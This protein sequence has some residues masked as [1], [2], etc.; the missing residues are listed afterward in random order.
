MNNR[1]KQ[2]RAEEQLEK[3]HAMDNNLSIGMK[4][5]A[6]AVGG[7]VVGALT[8]GIGLVPYIAVVGAAAVA[9]GGA[10]FVFSSSFLT[11][12]PVAYQYR[13]PSDSR[14]I[15]GSENS[16]EAAAWKAAIEEQIL[17]L[18][19]TRKPM[20]PATADPD[21]IS[22]ILGSSSVGSGWTKVGQMEGMRIM[23]QTDFNNERNFTEDMLMAI[24]GSP[25]IPPPTGRLCRKAQILVP[26]SPINAFLA[27][28]ELTWPTP[29]CTHRVV[30]QVDDHV[31]ILG[32]CTPLSQDRSSVCPWLESKRLLVG[33]LTR[34]WFLDD[35]GSYMITLSPTTN[36]EF[37][38][39]EDRLPHKGMKELPLS[40]DAVFTVS[41][42]KNQDLFDDD[43][44]QALVT[45][46]VQIN[47]K[48]GTWRNVC[49]GTR[50]EFLNSFVVQ[51][52]DLR[53]R[54]FLSK[55]ELEGEKFLAGR[56][57]PCGTTRPSG[58]MSPNSTMASG[59]KQPQP[60]RSTSG[61]MHTG[62]VTTTQP[63]DYSK[64]K[65]DLA[66]GTA[67]GDRL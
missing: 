35:D 14:L 42:H 32:V 55:F 64:A 62:G 53:D 67:G 56:G 50:N 39:P 33:A 2:R 40:L 65:K 20:L 3:H 41:P 8:A 44:R 37:P 12:L 6:V 52:L 21:V 24:S 29:Q 49:E 19:A 28:M 7:V 47:T 16:Q 54:I 25:L 61:E 51:L 26:C 27:L 1:D 48:D 5:A 58:S 59:R 57:A 18:E 22:R 9:S 23:Q 30:Q 34:F 60:Q 10:G 38:S 13:R 66:E 46:T 63:V 15:L 17:K 36:P 45:C 31:D 11:Y 4:V 43:L